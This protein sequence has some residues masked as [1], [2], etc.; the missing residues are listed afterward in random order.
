MSKL[1][2]YKKS[3]FAGAFILVSMAVHGNEAPDTLKQPA[4]TSKL[5]PTSML[6]ALDYAGD[7]I[8]AVGVKGHVLLSDD[9]G[10]SW[11]QAE[12]VP[13]TVTLTDVCFNTDTQGWAVGH[14][15]V[16]LNTVD[17]GEHW[18]LQYN[19]FGAARDLHK[20]LEEAGSENAFY[21]EMMVE[22]G[23]DKPF[24][25]IA[26]LGDDAAVAVGAY[27]FGFS[28]GNGGE[29][30]EPSTEVF[31]GTQQMHVYGAG[32][33]GDQI[34]MGGERG[35]LFRTDTRLQN[36]Q[37]MSSPY[38]G[39]YFGVV[40]GNGDQ[41]I[42]FGLRGNAF[43]SVDA[44]TTWQAAKIDTNQSLT[45]GKALANGSILLLDNAGRGWL[46]RDGGQSYSAVLADR[47]FSPTDLLQLPG[48]DVLATGVGGFARF[49]ANQLN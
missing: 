43:R 23:A 19:G 18:T 21:G 7:R 8:V 47:S 30:W 25:D 41:L 42:A 17:G 48:G 6:S 44:G 35:L 4:V 9:Q 22:D 13:V 27:G 16:I 33:A 26:C 5:A 40:G 31:D 28:T 20:A 34:F 37:Q 38:D 32:Q 49:S 36:Y 1:S 3:L 29:S 15:G 46:T 45:A 12:Q 24:L 2:G 10:A 11:R 14:R 39:T